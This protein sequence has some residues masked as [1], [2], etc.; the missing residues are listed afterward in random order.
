MRWTLLVLAGLALP[1]VAQA[2]V[3]ENA[4][5][6]GAPAP[7]AV[8]A[9]GA[10]PV[11]TTGN[12][13]AGLPVMSPD[14][15]QLFDQPNGQVGNAAPPDAGP[16]A[17]PQNPE[18]AGESAAFGGPGQVLPTAREVAPSNPLTIGGT[19]FLRAQ[20]TGYQDQPPKS[21]GWDEPNLMDVYLDARPNSRVRALAVGRLTYDPAV[22]PNAISFGGTKQNQVNTY[23]DQLWINFDI[24][25][26]V[27][28]T[29][30]KQ[31]VKWGTGHI[32]NPTDFLQPVKLNP[33]D[34]IDQ[35]TGVTLVKAHVPWESRGWN[36]YGFGVFEGPQVV[37]TLS[38]V[39]GALRAQ[40]VLGDAELSFSGLFQHGRKPRLGADIS[41]GLGPFDVYAEAGFHG[42]EQSQLV[43]GL[44]GNDG[45]LC[46]SPSS[47]G[48]TGTDLP[49]CVLLP[50][51]YQT[52]TGILPQVS[53]GGT[54]QVNLNDRDALTVGLEGFYNQAGTND[55]TTYP[56]LVLTG[57]FVPFYVGKWYGAVYGTASM[58]RGTVVHS[59]S[60]TTL[61]NLSDE[62]FVSRLDYNVTI[63]THLGLDLYGDVHYGTQG[64][65]FRFGINTTA[66]PT[67]TGQIQQVRVPTPTFDA[68]VSL[69][70]SM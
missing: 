67:G 40:V 49:R 20:L 26:E 28:V 13:D 37:N 31:H 45:Q 64:G 51:S 70:V 35:R 48:L 36:F 41:T 25:R 60:T 15:K 19:L 62:S 6:G 47:L 18:Q 61:G 21:W 55:A 24:L 2:Q 65:E 59:L 66:V 63:L 68:G 42:A 54:W 9:G 29:A 16:P 30:G 4:L 7:V 23:L 52:Q 22:D 8:D 56:V 32:W 14:E 11:T 3:D 46:V 27:F 43:A 39:G 53:A 5:F 44:G 1:A 12:T 38:Q 33:L 58:P 69:R 10:P 57:N 34:I 17:P 50:Y